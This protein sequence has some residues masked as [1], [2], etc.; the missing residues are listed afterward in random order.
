MQLTFFTDY[1][2][3]VLIYLAQ[4]PGERVTIDELQESFGVSRNHLVKV[5]HW[6]G[7]QGYITT[8]RG[9]GGGMTLNRDPAEMNIGQIFRRA[10]QRLDLV[11][12][13]G[14]HS[15]CSIEPSCG[16]QGVIRAGLAAFIEVVDRYTLADV[17]G[18][19]YQESLRL[20]RR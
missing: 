19:G 11:E 17:A 1:C 10:E 3:R 6:L 8:S 9:K 2:F 20:T 7:K 18:V 5:V 16:L 4:H 13:M 15:N 14:D 12:C